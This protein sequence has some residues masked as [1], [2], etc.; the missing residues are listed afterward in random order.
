M[1]TGPSDI[2]ALD[3]KTIYLYSDLLLHDMGAALA[4]IC[5]GLAAPSE[6]RTEML[7]GL[8]L[9]E[10]FLHDGSASSVEE[11]IA[12]HGGEAEAARAAFERLNSDDRRAL[13]HFLE[14]I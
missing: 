10:H 5:L 2:K 11:A 3:R 1:K 4:D 12:R 6:F 13:L 9:R 8:R 7:M 14:S